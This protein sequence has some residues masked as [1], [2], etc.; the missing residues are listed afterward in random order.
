MYYMSINI[1]SLVSLS[2]S[3]VI[4][5]KFGYAT[6]FVICGL[7]LIASLFSYIA[8][9]PAGE[10]PGGRPDAASYGRL[11]ARCCLMSAK[12]TKPANPRTVCDL[13]ATESS[14][15]SLFGV[16]VVAAVVVAELHVG[17]HRHQQVL[18]NANVPPVW[19]LA[20]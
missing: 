2:L 12:H 9:S 5:D 1:G 13:V 3:P 20:G 16:V 19:M 11:A 6:A 7:G 8:A 14:S 17:V 4:A 18:V 15:I 10:A